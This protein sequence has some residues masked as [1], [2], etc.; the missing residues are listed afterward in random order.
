MAVAQHSTSPA[1]QSPAAVIAKPPR[2]RGRGAQT[3]KPKAPGVQLP[4]TLPELMAAYEEMLSKDMGRLPDAENAKAM[5]LEEAITNTHATTLADICA[6]LNY[7]C[8]GID[9]PKGY[10]SSLLDDVGAM[11]T[12]EPGAAA[13]EPAASVV[14][15]STMDRAAVHLALNDISNFM[16]MVDHIADDVYRHLNAP[17]EAAHLWS[18][19]NG[20]HRCLTEIKPIILP[21]EEG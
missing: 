7:L 4:A 13:T 3:G 18:L 11:V 10:L 20:V 12:A 21:N 6:K 17:A 2:V 14:N 15:L 8:T 9:V 5:A 16:E 19:T 1:S